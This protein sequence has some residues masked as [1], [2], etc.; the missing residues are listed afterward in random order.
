MARARK[1]SPGYNLQEFLASF[2]L[3]PERGEI[4]PH[5][6]R[7]YRDFGYLFGM[8]ACSTEWNSR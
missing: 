4:I 6:C 5:E 1:A 2:R 7:S 8:Q 3:E